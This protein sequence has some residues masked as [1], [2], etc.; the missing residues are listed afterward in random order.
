MFFS[1][2]VVYWGIIEESVSVWFL[3]IIFPQLSDQYMYVMM[4][5]LAGHTHG[6]TMRV[7]TF[8]ILNMWKPISVKFYIPAH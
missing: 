7:M 1:L 8:D 3:E 4:L 6:I 2:L 5:L